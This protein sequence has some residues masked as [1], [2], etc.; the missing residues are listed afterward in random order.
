MYPFLGYC[1]RRENAEEPT[2]PEFSKPWSLS[3]SLEPKT[4]SLE[5]PIQGWTRHA[6]EVDGVPWDLLFYKKKGNQVDQCR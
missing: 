3:C 4:G 6:G 5:A 1:P 2:S